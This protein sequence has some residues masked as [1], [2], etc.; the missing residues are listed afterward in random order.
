MNKISLFI[1]LSLG[2]RKGV[3]SKR[4]S[5]YT[6]FTHRDRSAPFYVQVE[7]AETKRKLVIFDL[8]DVLG[9]LNT[10]NTRHW[11]QGSLESHLFDG[12][13]F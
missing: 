8:V 3:W 2:N 1:W 12:P 6:A 11:R 10:D 4:N 5:F 7:V 9:S 13:P